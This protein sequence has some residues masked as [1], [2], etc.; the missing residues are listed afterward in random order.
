MSAMQKNDGQNWRQF[1]SSHSTPPIMEVN[2]KLIF[3]S[4]Y[5]QHNIGA[6]NAFLQNYIDISSFITDDLP[7]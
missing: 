5:F 2:L 7:F 4:N 6:N 3:N 1:F